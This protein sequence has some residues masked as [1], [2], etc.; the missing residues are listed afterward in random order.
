MGYCDCGQ[1]T[2]IKVC[3]Y[4]VCPRCRELERERDRLNKDVSVNLVA[5]H[6]SPSPYTETPGWGRVVSWQ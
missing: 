6:P 1:R 2:A 3:G 4:W 5:H